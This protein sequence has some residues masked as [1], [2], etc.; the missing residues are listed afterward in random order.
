MKSVVVYV[1]CLA[2]GLFSAAPAVCGNVQPDAAVML[3]PSRYTIVQFAFDIARLRPVTP[4]AFDTPPGLEK[5]VVHRW[6]AP[7][8]DWVRVSLDDYRTG[9]AFGTVPPLAILVGPATDI[10]VAL[11]EP[12]EGC[13]RVMRIP[14]L[15]LVTLVNALNAQFNFSGREWEWLARRHGLVLKDLNAERRRWGRYGPPGKRP[16]RRNPD[17]AETVPVPAPETGSAPSPEQ[18]TLIIHPDAGPHADPPP[19]PEK[20]MPAEPDWNSDAAGVRPEDK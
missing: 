1:F 17:A 10:P 7:R 15:D 9:A 5:P 2:L 11:A 12:P 3:I 19:E 13:R 8:R 18:E 14:T 6:D 16:A 4:V 20:G